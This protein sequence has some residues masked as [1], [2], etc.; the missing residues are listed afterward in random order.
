MYGKRIQQAFIA[1]LKSDKTNIKTEAT[2]RKYAISSPGNPEIINIIYDIAGTKDLYSI[3]DIPTLESIQKAVEKT[4]VDIIQN[5][6]VSTA[7]GHYI[8]FLGSLTQSEKRKF[9]IPEAKSAPTFIANSELHQGV[10]AHSS[11]ESNSAEIERGGNKVER[12][13]TEKLMYF[14]ITKTNIVI[15]CLLLLLT[16]IIVAVFVNFVF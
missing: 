8:K 9:G 15:A 5:R 7:I 3:S 10:P 2:V 14:C 16:Q 11:S 13:D 4:D 12:M 1:Y 6:T